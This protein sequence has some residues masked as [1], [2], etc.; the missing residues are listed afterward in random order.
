[1]ENGLKFELEGDGSTYDECGK[2]TSLTVSDFKSNP[3]KDHD[4]VDTRIVLYSCT[5]L[6]NPV[7]KFLTFHIILE[8][9]IHGIWEDIQHDS[10]EENSFLLPWISASQQADLPE[11]PRCAEA[12]R[13]LTRQLEDLVGTAFNDAQKE[14]MKQLVRLG[15]E[16][17]RKTEVAMRI[18]YLLTLAP[19]DE[20]ERVIREEVVRDV[21]K[22]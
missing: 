6:E 2:E 11:L 15:V 4:P 9:G 8:V 7:S 22:S 16:A 3:W 5:S 12:A 14:M 13:I 10:L 17:A 20:I 18:R 19:M 21:M 1:M